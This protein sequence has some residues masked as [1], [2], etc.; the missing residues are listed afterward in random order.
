MRADERGESL[1]RDQLDGMAQQPLEQV[2]KCHEAIEALLAWGELDEKVH[3]AIGAG[4][5]ANHGAEERKAS[6]T[7]GGSPFQSQAGVASFGPGSGLTWS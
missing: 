5:A 3:V 6:D 2:G 7:V 1:D 4:L